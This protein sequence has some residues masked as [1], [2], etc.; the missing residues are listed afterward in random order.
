MSVMTTTEN[1]LFINV[2][3]LSFLT[4]LLISILIS[5]LILLKKIEKNVLKVVE[6]AKSITTTMKS[7]LTHKFSLMRIIN[8]IRK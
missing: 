8:L 6:D 3:L 4:I 1:L 7:R 5:V 2:L